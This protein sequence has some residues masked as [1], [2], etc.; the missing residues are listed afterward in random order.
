MKRK[1]IEFLRNLD[2]RWQTM[3]DSERKIAVAVMVVVTVVLGY[4]IFVYPVQARISTLQAKAQRYEKD[5]H[6]IASYSTAQKTNTNSVPVDLSISIESAIDKVAKDY[7][8]TVNK[9]VK[10]GKKAVSIEIEKIDSVDLFGFLQ[11]LENKYAIYVDGIDI[12]AI[13]SSNIT[14]KRLLVGRI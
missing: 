12:N 5:Y 4:F 3:S 7:G 9:M 11:D 8:I 13:D 6:T 1:I 10:S 14:V 2:K